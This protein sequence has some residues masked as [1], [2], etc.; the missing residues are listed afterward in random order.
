MGELLGAGT[1]K[2]MESNGW[3]PDH[4]EMT[5]TMK[6][7]PRIRGQLLGATQGRCKELSYLHRPKGAIAL[8]L[9][10]ATD[11]P[12]LLGCYEMLGMAR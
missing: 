9:G 10:L 11:I 6:C 7:N 2:A 12:A 4:R 5:Q 8:P 3:V 1:L